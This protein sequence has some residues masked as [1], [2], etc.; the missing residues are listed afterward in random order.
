MSH[1]RL[2]CLEPI[3]LPR[4]VLCLAQPSLAKARQS[5][6]HIGLLTMHSHNTHS[7]FHECIPHGPSS[8]EFVMASIGERTTHTFMSLIL[9]PMDLLYQF[10]LQ[11]VEGSTDLVGILYFLTPCTNHLR[12][13][14]V[15]NAVL[16][17]H[18]TY[19]QK[20]QQGHCCRSQQEAQFQVRQTVCGVVHY[21]SSNEPVPFSPWQ[22]LGMLRSGVSE[23]P[24]LL[25]NEPSS[26]L[27]IG[28]E[29]PIFHGVGSMPCAMLRQLKYRLIRTH[30]YSI[31][32]KDR[33]TRFGVTVFLYR[34]IGDGRNN[35]LFHQKSL[36]KVCFFH[37]KVCFFPNVC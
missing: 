18:T 35:R 15:P 34:I 5:M 2:M 11:I 12:D 22:V 6:G 14:S 4:N 16:P 31:E 29:C 7:T 20:K 28:R 13:A 10:L 26:L 3:H 19:G 24:R 21:L 30:V 8:I 32:S 36:G 37:L 33:L 23:I 27:P 1:L 25:A 17:G 9:S